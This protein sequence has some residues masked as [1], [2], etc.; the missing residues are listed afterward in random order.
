MNSLLGVDNYEFFIPYSQD[1]TI[2]FD[3]F[4]EFQD[5]FFNET[6]EYNLIN[7]DVIEEDGQTRTTNYEFQVSNFFNTS[8]IVSVQSE[9]PVPGSNSELQ[10][11][12]VTSNLVGNNSLFSWEQFDNYDINTF[13]ENDL[14]RLELQGIVTTGID[15]EGIPFKMTRIYSMRIDLR[16]STGETLDTWLMSID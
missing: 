4:E 13:P 5:Y 16:L 11:L 1:E 8:I 6:Q 14:L 3:D 12:N 9:I 10:I 2:K 15:V 7:M